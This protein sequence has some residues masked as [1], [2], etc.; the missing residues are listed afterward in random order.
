MF[1]QIEGSSSGITYKGQPLNSRFVT[2]FDPIFGHR[3]NIAPERAKRAYDLGVESTVEIS[4][5]NDCRFCNYKNE[6][7]EPRI[8]HDCGAVSF[9]N[10]FG[11]LKY[12]W[13]TTYPP[14]IENGN[15][16]RHKVLLSE[17]NFKDLERML[18]S[19][20]DI[21]KVLFNLRKHDPDI[22]G[23]MDFT[24][25]GPYAG[26]SVQHP[27][28]QRQGVDYRPDKVEDEEMRCCRAF[29]HK[30]GANPFDALIGEELL[31]RERVIFDNDKVYIGACFAPTR[32]DEIIVIP[33]AE[34]ANI[35]E[36][37]SPDDR[38]FIKAA[39]GVF[40]A[41]RCYR[42]VS[43]LNLAVHQAPFTALRVNGESANQYYRWHMHIIPRSSGLPVDIAGGELGFG[44]TISASLP[45]ELAQQIRHWYNRTPDES[46]VLPPL[47]TEFEAC[48]ARSP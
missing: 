23:L 5:K 25:W 46:L 42:G 37:S 2:R 9:P 7:P 24:N 39:L 3:V 44:V 27:H 16:G 6:T 40:P 36:T 41:L 8:L 14:F 32:P 13:V 26:A 34:F 47:R 38:T 19:E 1:V 15:N 10:L 45:E 30:Y 21:A 33:K 4:P 20:Y 28:S 11:W 43:N 31:N 35:I 22:L 48:I 12:Q 17:I 29:Y 18:E